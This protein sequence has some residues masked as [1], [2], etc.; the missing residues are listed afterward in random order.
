MFFLLI[1]A[2]ATSHI[3]DVSI[4]SIYSSYCSR[5]LI[6]YPE[7]L[8]LFTPTDYKFRQF[9]GEMESLIPVINKLQDVFNTVGSETI[10]LPQIVVIGNQVWLTVC[11]HLICFSLKEVYV[12][13]RLLITGIIIHFTTVDT[14]LGF[15]VCFCFLNMFYYLK[16]LYAEK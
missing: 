4:V 15:S 10:Q 14:Q 2:V 9:K 13:V 1:K 6:T 7:L 16:I 12:P 11:V 5:K 3:Q 8:A